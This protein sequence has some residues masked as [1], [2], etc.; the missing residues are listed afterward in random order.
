MKPSK[1]DS[2]SGIKTKISSCMGKN[3]L[4]Y[5]SEKSTLYKLSPFKLLRTKTTWQEVWNSHQ[6]MILISAAV[7][8][9][10]PILLFRPYALWFSGWSIGCRPKHLESIKNK[11]QVFLQNLI[12][13]CIWWTA[14]SKVWTQLCMKRRLALLH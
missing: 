5:R 1:Y 9:L 13:F 4:S 12:I 6:K 7:E 3:G 8:L 11:S 2:T 10:K 14:V